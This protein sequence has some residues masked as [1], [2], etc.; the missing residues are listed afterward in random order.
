MR[1]RRDKHVLPI[2]VHRTREATTDTTKPC[3]YSES[4]R[5][6]LRQ[7]VFR[8]YIVYFIQVSI[9]NWENTVLK[10]F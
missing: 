3:T 8:V 2:G 6:R 5:K 9:F 1:L 4:V 7:T 10:R